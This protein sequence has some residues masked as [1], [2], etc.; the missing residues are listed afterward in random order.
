MNG[1]G[2]HFRLSNNNLDQLESCE[3]GEG[4]PRLD[5]LISWGKCFWT[6]QERQGDQG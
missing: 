2:V 3:E 5:V 6:R 1:I 4:I